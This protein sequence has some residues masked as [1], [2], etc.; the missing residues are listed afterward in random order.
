MSEVLSFPLNIPVR[1]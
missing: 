1:S